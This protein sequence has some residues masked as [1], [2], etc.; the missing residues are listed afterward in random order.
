MISVTEAKLDSQSRQCRDSEYSLSGT[1]SV[2][3][4]LC[5]SGRVLEV[6][7]AIVDDVFGGGRGY[8]VAW[9]ERVSNQKARQRWKR[10]REIASRILGQGELRR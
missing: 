4:G 7:G 6:A 1:S 2:I 8:G 9:R 3:K 5:F 10:A